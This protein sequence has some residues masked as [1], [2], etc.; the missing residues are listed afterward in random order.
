MALVNTPHPRLDGFTPLE[1]LVENRSASEVITALAQDDL[2]ATAATLASELVKLLGADLVAYIASLPDAATVIRWTDRTETPDSD[3]LA[4][5][6]IAF[7]AAFTL[8]VRI[9]EAEIQAWMQV[10]NPRLHDV[11]PAR[12]LR[13][14]PI[15]FAG[16][17][18][19]AAA[20]SYAAAAG[21][22]LDPGFEKVLARARELWAEP[23]ASEWLRG[24]SSHL[25]GARPI[26]L[27]RL[28]RAAE[29]LG[30]LDAVEQGG[31]G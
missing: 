22:D 10:R 3:T 21:A 31:M 15:E 4:R 9:S 7:H 1:W 12:V 17:T 11:S 19:L 16:P 25:N 27:V 6:S 13:Q 29:V 20:R 2:P 30:A 28:G 24:T 18:V 8:Q 5:L 14:D 26:D 23:S